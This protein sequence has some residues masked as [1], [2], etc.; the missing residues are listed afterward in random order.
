MTC[1]CGLLSGVHKA[2]RDCCK[3]ASVWEN[4]TTVS[5]GSK[6]RLDDDDSRDR[7]ISSRSYAVGS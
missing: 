7:M 2:T 5:G 4:I 1:S 3:R 6:G